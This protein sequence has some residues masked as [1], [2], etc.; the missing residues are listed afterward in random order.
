MVRVRYARNRR[1]VDACQLWAFAALSRSPGAR[2]YYDQLRVKGQGHNQALRALAN[3]LV[4]ILHG[5]LKYRMP[6]CEEIAWPTL[7]EAAA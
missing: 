3:R 1:L 6:Y 7:V 5:C 4:G 2:W